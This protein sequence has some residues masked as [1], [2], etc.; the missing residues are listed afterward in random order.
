M[1][2]FGCGDFF[3]KRNRE[4]KVKNTKVFGFA[5]YKK[6]T[7]VGG[8]HERKA[9][10]KLKTKERGT[11]CRIKRRKQKENTSRMR[12]IRRR[13]FSF[14]EYINKEKIQNTKLNTKV[15]G[16][17][18]YKKRT[19]VGRAHERKAKHKEK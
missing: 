12:S 19:G 8:A 4:H 15:F 17:A 11:K 7:G 13:A 2:D 10:Q 14:A 9:K 6:R 5:F 18:F 16:F 3:A 1:S